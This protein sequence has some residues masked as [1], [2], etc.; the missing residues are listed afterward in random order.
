MRESRFLYKEAK[1]KN[2]ARE[3]ARFARQIHY[4]G[5]LIGTE[6]LKK[7]ERVGLRADSLASGRIHK[8][9]NHLTTTKN[10]QNISIKPVF[11]CQRERV[12]V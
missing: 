5:F 2:E 11:I 4:L 1:R 10:K 8:D 9:N 3:R 7:R 12:C 6:N